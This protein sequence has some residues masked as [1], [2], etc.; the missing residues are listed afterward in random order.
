MIPLPVKIWLVWTG[1]SMTVGMLT[2]ILGMERIND[3]AL[4]S[5]AFAVSS[6]VLLGLYYVVMY[7]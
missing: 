4:A 1:L 3:F 6:G 7:A 2:L 5:A